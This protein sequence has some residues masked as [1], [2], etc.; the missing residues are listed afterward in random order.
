MNDALKEPSRE[1]T[2]KLNW[3]SDQVRLANG[4]DVVVELQ[5]ANSLTIASLSVPSY[6]LLQAVSQKLKCYPLITP[7]GIV[8][9]ASDQTIQ[10]L[11]PTQSITLDQLIADGISSDMLDD[12]LNVAKMLSKLRTRLLKSL[13]HVEKAIASLPKD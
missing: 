1:L 11:P 6:Q 2:L 5:D 13:E 3:P 10:P 4:Q 8:S 7:G 9:V 12:E